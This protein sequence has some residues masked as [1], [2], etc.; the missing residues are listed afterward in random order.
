MDDAKPAT[1]PTCVL[2]V[3]DESPAKRR[4]KATGAS[5]D[6]AA[7]AA[8]GAS[9]TQTPMN[10]GSP[11]E[12]SSD[13]MSDDQPY[14]TIATLPVVRPVPSQL[15]PTQL[16]PL[17]SQ[18]EPT[19]LP[20]MS[21]YVTQPTQLIDPLSSSP[22][23]PP[24]PPPPHDAGAPRSSPVVQVAASSPVAPRQ[25]P[26]SMTAAGGILA[27]AMAPAGTIYRPPTGVPRPSVRPPIVDLSDDD[28]P[29]Y[30]GN[31]SDEELAVGS[32]ADIKPST[33][34]KSSLG[35]GNGNANGNVNGPHVRTGNRFKDLMAASVYRPNNAGEKTS[36][37]AS[38]VMGHMTADAPDG[39]AKKRRQVGPARAKPAAELELNDIAD[40]H[41]REKTARLKRIFP[42]LTVTT[43]RDTLLMT[44]GN[45]DEAFLR[46]TAGKTTSAVVDLDG[47]DTTGPRRPTAK[48]TAKRELK[49]PNRTIQDKWSSTQVQPPPTA[50]PDQSFLDDDELPSSPPPTRASGA[51]P[52][53]ALSQAKSIDDFSDGAGS[54]DSDS[55]IGSA[56]EMEQQQLAGKVL[57]F[58]NTCAVKDLADI[59]NQAEATAQLIL[60]QRPFADLAAVRRVSSETATT[61]KAGKRRTTRKPIGD[62]IVDTCLDMWT[63][64]EAVDDLVT[65]CE[66]LGAPLAA[67]MKRWGLDVFGAAKTGELEMV[68]L[69]GTG[70]K[71]ALRD[72]GIGTPSS[73]PMTPNGAGSGDDRPP[74]TTTTTTTARTPAVGRGT[75]P[76]FLGQPG[77]MSPAI[78]LKDYQVV[79]L[80]W[81]ALLYRHQLSGI[82]ADEMGLGKTCQV[83]AFLAHLWEQGEK[84]PHLI[85]VPGSTLENWLRE[86]RRFCPALVV[87][88]YYGLEKDRAEQRV[89]LADNRAQ[90]NAIVTTYDLASKKADG[91]FLRRLRATVCVFDEGHALKNSAS[92]RYEALMRIPARFRLLLTGTPL[93]NNL[94]ELAALLGF[95]LPRLFNE[96]R[97]DLDYIFRARATTTGHDGHSALL[98]AQRI[99]RARSMMTPFVLRRKK[100]QVLQHLPPK[101]RRTEL[102]DM[103]AGQRALY[104][105]QLTRARD[106]ARARAAGSQPATETGN[107]LMQLRKAAIHPMLFRQHFDDGTLA[108]MARDCLR[109]P[110]LRDRDYGA[111][112]DDMRYMS[113]FQLHAFCRAHPATMAGHDTP[114]A[115]WMAAGKVAKLAELLAAFRAAGDRTLVFSQFTMVLDILE[116]VLDTLDMPYFRLDGAT[117]IDERQDMIDQFHDEREI[118]VFLLSTRAGGMGINLACANR[119]VIFDQSFNPQE[120]IQAENR[121]HRVGQTREVQVVRLVSRG[122]VEE[123]IL[124]LGDAKLAL[125]E[126]VA[127]AGAGGDGV[128]AGGDGELPVDD[129]VGAG[130]DPSGKKAEQD[131]LTWMAKLLVENDGEPLKVD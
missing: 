75:A 95:I 21:A 23:P 90:I 91:K 76:Q 37:R 97:G 104:E 120:D 115:A 14:E 16:L 74:A 57:R 87:E 64:Y 44:H 93:Q 52:R 70:T 24:P 54:D 55:A 68:S 18:L 26:A 128:G 36:K 31:T 25:P 56:D 20:S 60:A 34:A 7:A 105:A 67:E 124:A 33:F 59:S 15:E 53:P 111:V 42:N 84:G 99:A 41:L 27:G 110:A 61:T 113:D 88:P 43:C 131:A 122:T 126:R 19:Q 22:P 58:F 127:G 32:K 82:L 98:S 65:Q 123:Q 96:R 12:L 47:P 80:N 121:A 45:A 81:L 63:G 112:L 66:A 125:D 38:D 48:A 4:K 85:I 73:S 1:T 77:I 30:R 40:F 118:P 11:Y 103:T 50:S 89:R 117:R 94:K 72:S 119:V 100:H 8:N 102:C 35:H 92:K 10:A 51:K 29:T 109:E 13:D 3:V 106:A 46:L 86:F 130:E 101:Q 71:P 69:V 114:P 2:D 6:D 49:A 78:S 5:D 83:I 129:G 108:R 17:P 28:G 9:G 116:A 107:V 62:K 39:S 79:G